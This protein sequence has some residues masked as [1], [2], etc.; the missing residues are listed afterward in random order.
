MKTALTVVCAVYV[1]CILSACVKPG[2]DEFQQALKEYGKQNYDVA[3]DLFNQTLAQESNYSKEII[4]SMMANVYIAQQDFSSAVQCYQQA[5]AE[6]PDYRIFCTVGA[7]Y[8]KIDN[9]SAAENAYR[10]AIAFDAKR[11]EAYASL[12]ALYLGQENLSSAIELLENAKNINPKLSVVHA[13]LAVAYAMQ[14]NAVRAQ[15]ELSIAERY[16]CENFEQ[17]KARVTELLQ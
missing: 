6:K 12:G 5:L 11:P 13:N 17:F 16:K 2:D 7:L 15:E 14:K 8:Q 1:F 10:D 4:Y 3:L 9:N